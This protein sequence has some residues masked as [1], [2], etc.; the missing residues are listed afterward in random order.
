MVKYLI[1]LTL[2]TASF[3]VNVEPSKADW[4]DW[5]KTA[6]KATARTGLI[7]ATKY[8]VTTPVP[9]GKYAPLMTYHDFYPQDVP[10]LKQRCKNMEAKHGSTFLEH[11]GND[12]VCYS[13][14]N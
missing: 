6:G 9:L 10:F 8:V 7:G 11:N 3:F 12:Y 5:L 4:I 2:I 14:F 13:M 1:G